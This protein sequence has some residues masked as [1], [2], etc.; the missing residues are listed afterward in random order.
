[1]LWRPG[2]LEHRLI[3]YVGLGLAIFCVIAGGL[4]YR[5]AYADQHEASRRLQQQIVRTVL[6]QAEVAAFAA[7]E[8]IA[9]GV[10]DGLLAN[11]MILAVR[12]ES[13]AKF[14]VE[15]GTRRQIDFGKATVYPLFSP[16][17]QLER[18]GELMVSAN[19]DYIDDLAAREALASTTLM[20]A[21]V[22]L[23]GILIMLASRA[24]IIRPIVELARAVAG[25]RPGSG[26]RIEVDA[27]HQRDE[28]GHLSVS[29]NALIDAAE[30]AMAELK[31]L[32]T[33]D[34]LTGVCNRRHFVSRLDD[35][36]ARVQRHETTR[37]ALLMLDLDHFKQINDVRGHPA[38]DA[39]LR[40]IGAMMREGVRKI[41]TVGRL[42]GEEFAIL[43]P[44]TDV[45]A[46]T[47]FAERL[48]QEVERT[49]VASESGELRVTV[50]IGIAIVDPRD[51][52]SEA[53]MARADEALY[54]AKRNGRNRVESVVAGEGAEARA[55]AGLP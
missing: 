17:D 6:A 34:F 10:I 14:K 23:T 30:T 1:M 36:L 11:P 28:I 5:R 22:L 46:A 12:L 43:L 47:V 27:R 2:S 25:I 50:S 55:P 8:R 53:V 48:R 40:Q 18:V 7:N 38:G 52:G 32:A 54:R 51:R 39:V 42:G 49:P 33:T 19:D 16:V 15:R 44:A 24:V 20:L 26:A 21:Q 41:D 13:S 4:T 45:A 37:T 35:E 29:A 3:L 31:Q 9:S